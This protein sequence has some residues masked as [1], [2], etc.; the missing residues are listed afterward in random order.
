MRQNS[1]N[2]GSK[3]SPLTKNVPECHIIVLQLLKTLDYEG[4]STEHIKN[5]QIKL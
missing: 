3:C 4:V 5:I 2:L 1:V